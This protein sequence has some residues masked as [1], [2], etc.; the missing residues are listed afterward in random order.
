[1]RLNL[2]CG[3]DIRP[4]YTNVDF[5][6]LTADVL[7]VDLSRFPWPFADRSADEILMLDFLEHFE[8]KKIDA[9]LQEAWR[10]LVPAGELQVQVPDFT[11]CAA[12]V[13]QLI[14]EYVCNRCEKEFSVGWNVDHGRVCSNCGQSLDEMT[15][16][17][18]QRL[19]GGQDYTGNYHMFSFTQ[20]TLEKRLRKN[21][22][23]DFELLEAEHQYRMWNFKARAKK[24]DLGWA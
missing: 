3:T 5:R 15:Q 6:A 7:Q 13:R 10:V 12:A 23:C 9:I 21:G 2:G 16:V 1:M 18:M 14:G 17:A 8:Y 24:G 22:F 4:G 19:F 20:A 11:Q